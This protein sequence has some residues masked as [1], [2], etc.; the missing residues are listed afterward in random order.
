MEVDYW[1]RKLNS[2][3]ILVVARLDSLFR[4]HN[5]RGDLRKKAIDVVNL[6]IKKNRKAGYLYP[7]RDKSG[8]CL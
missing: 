2:L 6:S 4:I 1:C 8:T 3:G 5:P 7:C